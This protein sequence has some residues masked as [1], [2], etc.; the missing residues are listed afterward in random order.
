MNLEFLYTLIV[1]CNFFLLSIDETFTL[2][3]NVPFLFLRKSSRSLVAQSESLW[4]IK[5]NSSKSRR[6]SVLSSGTAKNRQ[7]NVR[8]TSSVFE[9]L[10]NFLA[11]CCCLTS[12]SRIEKK[13][14][15][16]LYASVKKLYQV[17]FL[18]FT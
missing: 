3:D 12:R 8:Y 17:F 18:Y 11:F 2:V 4:E 15:T 7:D 13:G 16:F 14:R 6:A 5:K 10:L 9:F 1:R